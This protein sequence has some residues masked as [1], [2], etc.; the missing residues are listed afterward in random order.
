MV[1]RGATDTKIKGSNL[2]HAKKK[3]LTEIKEE[4]YSR[5]KPLL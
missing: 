1:K 4:Y 3:K 5:S 2:L